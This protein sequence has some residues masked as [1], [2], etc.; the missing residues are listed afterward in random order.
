M[1]DTIKLLTI[2]YILFALAI[3]AVIYI[4]V[5][6][7]S[8]KRYESILDGLER[9]K[10]LILNANISSELSKVESMI[11][12]K[13]IE[14]KYEEWKSRFEAIKNEDI[15]ALTDSLIEI[16]DLFRSKNYKDIESILAKTELNI[17]HVKTKANYLLDEIKNLTY[18]E[19]RNRE[20]IT[21]LKSAYRSIKNAYRENNSMY[22][23]I[24]TPI[25]LQF[26]TID[27]LF[28][29]FELAMD[30]HA[31]SEISKII[32]ALDDS[33]NNLNLVIEEAPEIIL[34]ASRIIPK[35]MKDVSTIYS[36]MV[37]EGYNLDYLQIDYNKTEAEKKIADVFDRLNVLNLEDS[38]LELKTID[39]YFDNIYNDFDKER[40]AKKEFSSVGANI[41]E[42][43]NKLLKIAANL[44]NRIS[45]IK[46]DYILSDEDIRGLSIIEVSI[47]GV[48]EDYDL[49]IDSAKKKEKRYTRLSKEMGKLNARLSKLEDNLDSLLRLVSG[50]KMDEERARTELT[51]IK[52]MLVSS[53]EKIKTY[54]MPVIP[55]NYY[56]YLAEA[57]EAINEMSKELDK[58]P[59]NIEV[60]NM[61]VNNARDLTLK[62]YKTT[63]EIVK[64]ASMSENA[65]VYGNRYRSTNDR[66]DIGLKH[67][68]EFFFKGDF[69]KSLETAIESL[70]IVE[71]GIHEKLI[72]EFKNR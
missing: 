14:K 68:E 13:D 32:K 7:N 33:I 5:R 20:T 57:D 2:T 67:A 59:I 48:L 43:A 3:V 31:Y 19:E 63:N 36:N 22:E 52:K 4:I 71:P 23:M 38:I 47:R 51:E 1:S 60:L 18:S 65:I 64:T 39:S 69:K 54:K 66:V 70:N 6:K 45:D 27:K 40:L 16:E 24:K 10:N 46:D 26:E 37:K 28:S 61:R 30:K 72:N 49:I 56:I 8:K 12:S 21:K 55:K 41:S 53:K 44:N 29:A 42:K 35:K 15:P 25:E 50:Y 62:L 9:E 11:N 34:L 17:Y 58:K